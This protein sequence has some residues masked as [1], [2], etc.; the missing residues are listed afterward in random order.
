MN[1]FRLGCI[2]MGLV[3]VISGCRTET[4]EPAPAQKTVVEPVLA[5]VPFVQEDLWGYKT[6]TGEVVIAPRYS[7]AAD[8]N[9]QG[10]AIVVD[11]KGWAIIDRRGAILVRPFIYDNGPDA[12]SDGLARFVEEGKMGY[13]APSGKVVIAAQYDFAWPFENGVAEVCQDCARVADGEHFRI[14][15]GTRWSIDK[16]GVKQAN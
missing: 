1:I 11:D 6:E 15:G 14:E 4:V 12:F 7:M 9:A 16:N 5:L 13:F 8:F 2:H 3:L 10:S